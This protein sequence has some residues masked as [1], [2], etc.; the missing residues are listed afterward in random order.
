MLQGAMSFVIT[1]PADKTAWEPTLTPGPTQHPAPSQA[2]SSM[3]IGLVI[4]LKVVRL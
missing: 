3:V 4:K 1:E 2:P